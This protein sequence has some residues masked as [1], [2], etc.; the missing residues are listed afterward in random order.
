[1]GASLITKA[2]RLF[3][4]AWIL[5]TTAGEGMDSTKP[6]T[7]YTQAPPR[8]EAA[9]FVS[10]VGL[11]AHLLS[12]SGR[13]AARQQPGASLASHPVAPLAFILAVIH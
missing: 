13:Q 9:P 3:I 4:A 12:A 5:C 7:F 2:S 11:A 10:A 1:M 6:K 8:Q